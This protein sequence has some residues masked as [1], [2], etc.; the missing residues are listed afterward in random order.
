MAARD[1]RHRRRWAP[2]VQASLSRA[3]AWLAAATP[4]L[5]HKPIRSAR[6]LSFLG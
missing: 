6:S 3:T 5:N 2:A 1:G 4:K